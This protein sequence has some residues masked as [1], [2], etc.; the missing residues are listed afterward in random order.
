[1]ICVELNNDRSKRK[2]KIGKRRSTKKNVFIVK[3]V[4]VVSLGLITFSYCY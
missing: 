2:N 3:N 1:L 4:F